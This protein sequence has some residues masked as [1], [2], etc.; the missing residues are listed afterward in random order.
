MDLQNR[1]NFQRERSPPWH[2]SGLEDILPVNYKHGK[3][4]KRPQKPKETSMQERMS[5]WVKEN[6]TNV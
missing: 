6:K 2:V 4:Y 3:T 1:L 5:N